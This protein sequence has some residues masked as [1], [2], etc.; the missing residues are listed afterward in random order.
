MDEPA[1]TLTEYVG[2]ALR[3]EFGRLAV[4]DSEGAVHRVYLPG[5]RFVTTVDTENAEVV[6]VGKLIGEMQGSAQI[7]VALMREHPREILGRYQLMP[8]GVVMAQ[9]NL[10][11]EVVTQETLRR[12]VL[13]VHAMAVEGERL[14]RA[15][16]AVAVDLTEILEDRGDDDE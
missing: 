15:A 14:L 1:T 8:D 4:T 13:A 5:G 12:A 7:C 3:E 9:H 2:N 11:A 16:G 6:R 10:L